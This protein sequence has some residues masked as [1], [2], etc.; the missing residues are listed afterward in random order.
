[1]CR[2]KYVTCAQSSDPTL[3]PDKRKLQVPRKT[4]EVYLLQSD[5]RVSW[6]LEFLFQSWVQHE[7]LVVEPSGDLGSQRPEVTGS[8]CRFLALIRNKSFYLARLSFLICTMDIPTAT[9]LEWCDVPENTCVRLQTLQWVDRVLL[10]SEQDG[11]RIMRSW[12]P[13]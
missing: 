1:M 8:L 4:H 13:S 3:N 11:Y 7:T 10:G 6:L 9:L 2:Y 5:S 12:L